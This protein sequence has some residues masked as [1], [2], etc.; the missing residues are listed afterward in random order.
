M[1]QRYLKTDR[2]L[3]RKEFKEI[4]HKGS[5]LVGKYVVLQF[6]FKNNTKPKLGI[7]VTKKFG[8]AHD[9]NRF[10]RISRE[11]FRQV[12]EEISENLCLNLKPR[13]FAKKAKTQ[14][15]MTEIKSLSEKCHDDFKR[16]SSPSN[17][18]Q[19]PQ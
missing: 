14:D 4:L 19:P 3:R 9:R 12:K 8:K 17:R 5:S 6:F 10:K 15:I 13:L 16:K 1:S 2:L 18:S 11:A 7:T